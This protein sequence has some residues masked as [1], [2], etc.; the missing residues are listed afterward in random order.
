MR[1]QKGQ[2]KSS[3]LPSVAAG[4]PESDAADP[5]VASKAVAAFAVAAK[6][7]HAA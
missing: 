7:A 4:L 3:P 5:R 6:T 2:N 1:M